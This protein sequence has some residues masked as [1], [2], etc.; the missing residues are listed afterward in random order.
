MSFNYITLIT[1]LLTTL[2][3]SNL[4]SEYHKCPQNQ[5]NLQGKNCKCHYQNTQI[6]C[7]NVHSKAELCINKTQRVL[8]NELIIT[9]SHLRSLTLTH[10]LVRNLGID[11]SALKRL[12]ITQG[13]SLQ[14]VNICSL[15]QVGLH[16]ASILQCQNLTNLNLLDLRN[17]RLTTLEEFHLPALK[18]LYL[19]GMFVM[20]NLQ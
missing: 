15:N 10:G 6:I 9:Q 14:E 11:P 1:L 19:S 2:T 3:N 13:S 8:V 16:D 20:S 4:T 7:C 5:N 17:N 12:Q 18:Q